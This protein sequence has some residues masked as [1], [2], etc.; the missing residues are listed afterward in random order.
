MSQPLLPFPIGNAV[1]IAVACIFIFLAIKKGYEPLL[2]LPIGFGALIVNIPFSGLMTPGEG[3]LWWIYEYGVLKDIFPCLLFI[4]IGV[5][6]DFGALIERPWFL[7][8]AA[9]GQLGIFIAM[10]CALAIGFTPF[11]AASI[12]I[13]GAMDGPTA[14]F[15]TSKF[16][17]EL[18]GPVTVCAYS[19]MALVP[20]LQIP[21]SKAL[22]T[23]KERLTRMEYK[24]KSYSRIVRILFPVIVTLVTGVIAP[25][26]IPLMGC[27][28][29]GN[30]MKESGVVDRL[31]KSA[32]NEIANATTI[33]L[34]LTIGGTMIADQFLRL[35]TLLIFA[36]GLVAFVSA[37][38]CGVLVAKLVRV[39]TKGKVNPLIGACGISA[40]PM[41]A[42]TAHRIGRE[43]DSS[44]WL[45]PHAM[46]TNV[47]GQIG[48]VVA[49]GVVLTYAPVI[50]QMLGLMP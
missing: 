26:G 8:F 36:L 21:I 30:L 9:A 27:L 1:M 50:I 40:F 47:G 37:I 38:A 39:V 48:S 49:G 28:M 17:Q 4:G 35:E 41:A 6:C 24:P 23:R 33:L 15:V 45:L 25:M 12:G 18:L 42:R 16:A 44:N 22:T 29:F 34:G 31:A 10:L 46:A 7:I 2:L 5:M 19:Y 20:I 32:E 11:Q 13:I 3:F 43:E 14:I